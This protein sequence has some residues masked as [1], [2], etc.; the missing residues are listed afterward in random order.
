MNMSVSIF[1]CF[2][3]VN[4]NDAI[5]GAVYLF[6]NMQTQEQIPA[7]HTQRDILIK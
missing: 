3:V 4:T 6:T 2:L 1:T 7:A 5:I